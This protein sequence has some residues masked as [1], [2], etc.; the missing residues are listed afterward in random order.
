MGMK[1]RKKPEDPA[2]T[3]YGAARL[4]VAAYLA[5]EAS[6]D[7]FYQVQLA[8]AERTLRQA[9]HAYHWERKQK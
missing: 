7:E 8:F 9:A 2:E 6:A 1:P 3:L 4:Y 5:H